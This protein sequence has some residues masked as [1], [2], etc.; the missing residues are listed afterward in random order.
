MTGVQAYRDA[1]QSAGFEIVQERGR[2]EFA[3]E[4]MERMMARM[5]QS[6]P[7]V[8]G[9]QLLIGEKTGPMMQGM[10]AMMKEG[11]LEPVELYAR[12]I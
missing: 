6:G 4:F 1:L 9:L 10:L 11:I 3:I 7:P 2:R 12:A 5:A 8:V